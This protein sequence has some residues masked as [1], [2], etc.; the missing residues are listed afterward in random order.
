MTSHSELMAEL[1]NT[2]HVTVSRSM[3]VVATTDL[4]RLHRMVLTS[5]AMAMITQVLL[6]WS[7]MR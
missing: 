6:I 5:L 7:M 2:P 4:R 3:R 1:P